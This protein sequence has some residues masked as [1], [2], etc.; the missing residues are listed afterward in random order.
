MFDSE[1]IKTLKIISQ[2]KKDPEGPF[3]YNYFFNV[4]FSSLRS[5]I[6]SGELRSPVYYSV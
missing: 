2:N 1:L 6:K 4:Q 3:L 5:L